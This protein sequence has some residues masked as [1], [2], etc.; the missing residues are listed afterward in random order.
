M[1]LSYSWL[2]EFLPEPLPVDELCAILTDLGL[3]VDGVQRLGHRP[4]PAQGLVLG[5]VVEVMPHPKADRLRI[6]LVDV[7]EQAPR[8]IVCGA[9]NL[10]LDQKVVVALPGTTLHRAGGDPILIQPASLRG[11]DS[12][13]MLC[14]AQEAGLGDD[15]SGIMVLDDQAFSQPLGTPMAILFPEQPGE[16]QIEVGL[17]PNRSDAMS[18]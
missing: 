15:S 5:K 2:C 9:P 8:Q 12:F 7:G 4:E 13:G 10:A 14:S 1:L 11:V 6:A 18:H 3:E 17:T 16:W